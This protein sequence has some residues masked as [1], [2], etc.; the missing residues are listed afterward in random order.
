MICLIETQLLHSTLSN[1]DSKE[2][3]IY[4]ESCISYYFKHP[5]YN[6][7]VIIIITCQCAES[8]GVKLH[9]AGELDS[10]HQL[11]SFFLEF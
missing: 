10:I 2:S 6:I 11:E 7:N 5:L 9:M 3:A 1:I 4:K 8:D